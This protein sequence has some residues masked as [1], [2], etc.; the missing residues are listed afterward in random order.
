[1]D[2]WLLYWSPPLFELRIITGFSCLLCFFSSRNPIVLRATAVSNGTHPA[3]AI[4]ATPRTIMAEPSNRPL[5][6]SLNRSLLA[7]TVNTTL[8]RLI[9]MTY[10]TGRSVS[11]NTYAITERAVAAPGANSF[12]HSALGITEGSRAVS[13]NGI[14]NRA[15]AVVM[16][17]L[18]EAES[19]KQ[20][21]FC[22]D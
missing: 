11:A 7:H 15:I 18:R 17:A 9:A 3:N 1:M 13:R 2:A 19:S 14:L 22:Q 20:L 8:V 16:E 21:P 6:F 4:T 5:I 12:H 10:G